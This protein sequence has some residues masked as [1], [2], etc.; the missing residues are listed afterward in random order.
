LKYWLGAFLDLYQTSERHDPDKKGRAT[1]AETLTP[2][3]PC[4]EPIDIAALIPESRH[5]NVSLI[6]AMLAQKAIPPRPLGR[7]SHYLYHIF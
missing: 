5:F 3:I 6:Y 1:F 4:R 7:P 2:A